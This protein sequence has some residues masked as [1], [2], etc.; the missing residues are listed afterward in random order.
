MCGET[1]ELD[2]EKLGKTWESW[3]KMCGFFKP[4]IPIVGYLPLLVNRLLERLGVYA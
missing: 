1:P 2:V 4:R 3:V